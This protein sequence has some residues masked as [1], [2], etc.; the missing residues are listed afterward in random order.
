MA[1]LVGGARR[2]DGNW[3]G[4]PRALA[5]VP[6]MSVGVSMRILMVGAEGHARVCL[7]ALLDEPR[8][9]VIGAISGEGK[10]I[11]G[12]PIP[13]LGLD[14]DFHRI[15]HQCAADRVF[16]AIGD[17]AIRAAVT[18]RC[19]S[20]GAIAAIAVSG[21]ALVSRWADLEP[22]VA[23][24][25]GA[26]VNAA[27]RIGRGSIVNTNASVDHD[28]IIG[29][30]VHVA[31]GVAVCGGVTVGEGT[32]IG[33]GARVAPNVSIGAWAV[34]AAGAVVLDDVADGTLV[35]GIPAR[36]RRAGSS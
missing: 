10:G 4:A 8:H 19:E 6:A 18:S 7:E 9:Q 33:V 20:L 21:H 23:L 22:G 36:S 32:L 11:A 29:E 16:V 1:A 2:R 26:V 31:P 13:V 35:A 25:P 28:C 27:T 24:L 30:F 14:S 5:I 15:W 34:V 17:N 12:L 3:M